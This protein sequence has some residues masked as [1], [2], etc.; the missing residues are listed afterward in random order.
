MESE[1]WSVEMKGTDVLAYNNQFSDSIG[2]TYGDPI[3]EKNSEVHLG[4]GSPD[5]RYGY[6]TKPNDDASN[7]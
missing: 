2:A 4:I 7:S 3:A 5:S 6:L 1:F